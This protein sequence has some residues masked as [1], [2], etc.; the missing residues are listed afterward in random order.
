[1]R[2]RSYDISG[3]IDPFL[4][5]ILIKIRTVADI[6]GVDFFLIGATVRDLNLHHIYNIRIY[7]KTND[8]DFAV[9]LKDWEEY[10]RFSGELE[11]FGFTRQTRMMHRF[12]YS[13]MV[14]D[15]LPFGRIAGEDASIIW[16]D[17]QSR[18]MSIEGFGEAYRKADDIVIS[19][20]PGI[21]IKTAS[22][23]SLA[24]LKIIAWNERTA[25]QRVR[26]A[27]DLNLLCSTYL[28][29][30]NYE[31]LAEEHADILNE[32]FDYELS[33]AILL[34][35][36]IRNVF[37]QK[38]IETVINILSGSK[39]EQLAAEM[40]SYELMKFDSDTN[41]DRCRQLLENL[42]MGLKE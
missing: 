39:S 34:G 36:D 35:R 18:V 21:R 10:E 19:T 26:D 4:K 22:V 28:D 16:P 38:T 15:F 41:I 25:E 23:Q 17:E 20:N 6:L 30:G 11:K 2:M 1:M 31:R 40:A 13:D 9:S 12:T 27:K 5:E 42:L 24:V 37:G 8:V 14:F 33:G 29:A 32:H 7:R 3:K